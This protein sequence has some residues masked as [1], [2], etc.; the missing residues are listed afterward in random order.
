MSRADEWTGANETE[1]HDN[2]HPSRRGFM[3]LAAAI[4]GVSITGCSAAGGGDGGA[5]PTQ[6]PTQT[7]TAT[8]T[9]EPT[10]TQPMEAVNPDVPISTT[11]S[12]L[13]T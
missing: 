7:P 5:D 1:T 13:S 2:R 12:R 6:T 9:E 8:P 3:G 4:G 11:R 10:T